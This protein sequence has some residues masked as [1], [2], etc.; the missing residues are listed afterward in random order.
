MVFL[1]SQKQD[2]TG[3]VEVSFSI[4]CDYVDSKVIEEKE[5]GSIAEQAAEV[6]AATDDATADM[7]NGSDEVE[8]DQ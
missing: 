2:E 5:N 7:E 6:G 8:G 3:N 1:R 4:N